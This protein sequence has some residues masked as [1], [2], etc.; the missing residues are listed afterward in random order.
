M[1]TITDMEIQGGEAVLTLDSALEYT[2]SGVTEIHGDRTLEV[3]AEV[4]LLTRTVV[5]R[6]RYH[7]A[8][9][10]QA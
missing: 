7:L 1:R 3:R 8:G 4:G 9:F 2:H 5:V 10:A 6:G